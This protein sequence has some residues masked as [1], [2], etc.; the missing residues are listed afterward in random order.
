MKGFENEIYRYLLLLSNLLAL[1]MLFV[2]FKWPRAGRLLF[3]FL[4]AWACW[5]N[6]TTALEKPHVYLEY[7]TLT[8]SSLYRDIING[9]FSRHILLSVGFIA[10]C[11]G[12]IAISMLLQ[13]WIF[14]AGITCGII[15]LVA[16]IPFGIGSGF[17]ATLILAIGMIIL[18]R[19]ADHVIWRAST[20]A[21]T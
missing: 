8:W 13:G 12:I 10:T 15:F 4:F 19:K 3:F 11:Q 1:I 7:G 20:P 6:W 5:M 16:I 17:P 14:K 2:S 9:W 18:M 21:I